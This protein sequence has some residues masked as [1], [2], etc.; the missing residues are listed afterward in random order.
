MN[1]NELDKNYQHA[2]QI[3]QK[4]GDFLIN[5]K[6]NKVINNDGKDVKLSADK[7][8]E[9][10][11]IDYLS[12]NSDIPILSEECGFVNKKDTDLLW[13]IDP[14][15]GSLN[16]LRDIPS[17]CVSIGLW[18]ADQPL[19][20]VVYDF[21]RQEMFGGIV[22]KGAWLNE[23]EMKVSNISDFSQA[24]MVMG[25]PS[26]GDYSESGLLSFTK[27]LQK[28]K[29]VRLL[30]SAALSLAY[31][32]CGRVEA[33]AERGINKWDIGAGAAIVLAAGGR[34]NYMKKMDKNKVDILL[35][36]GLL[37]EK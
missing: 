4:A 31:V 18:K 26:W 14:L 9:K 13:I 19:L 32:A 34:L 25:F 36:N 22:G 2:L 7:E 30:G 35:D 1:T 10:I 23:K 24:I 28:Y 6:D 20:G 21:N 3:A 37:S 29:K 11:I 15:D 12:K 8:A 5:Y 33:Y 27:V 16:Y 17:C